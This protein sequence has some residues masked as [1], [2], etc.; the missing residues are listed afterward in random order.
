M[1]GDRGTFPL[2]RLVWAQALLPFVTI[3]LTYLVSAFHGQVEWCVPYWESCTSISA[4]GR[5]VPA[6][7][8]FKLGMIPAALI[9]IA[10]WWLTAQW[11]RQA[12][13]TSHARS[14]ALLPWIGAA[15]AIF[16]ILYTVTLGEE[17]E[18]A[19]TLRRSGV[20]LAFALTYLAQLLMTRLLGELATARADPW[21]QA[22]HARLLALM[23]LLLCVGLLSLALDAALG[24]RY[25][26]VE[27]AF[28]W[29][30]ALLLNLYFAGL[31]L[32]LRREGVSVALVT[33]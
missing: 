8:L 29:V 24:P 15:A 3:H 11:R 32:V 2:H 20:I 4:T 12:A 1:P 13:P 16:L 9:A 17:G 10:L 6:K 27:D 30:M 31:A 18:A 19:G 28:E 5:E 14:L 23:V 33:P 25:D 26:E 7:F 22:W 21:L